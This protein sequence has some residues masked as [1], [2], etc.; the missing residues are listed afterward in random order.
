MSFFLGTK[1]LICKVGMIILRSKTNKDE[2]VIRGKTGVH[3]DKK[4]Y[5]IAFIKRKTGDNYPIYNTI[6]KIN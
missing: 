4:T 6:F 1:V 5:F 2:E 3:I